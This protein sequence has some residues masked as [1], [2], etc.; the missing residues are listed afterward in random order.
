MN[1]QAGNYLDK[2]KEII[3]RSQGCSN[4]ACIPGKAH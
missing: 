1:D 2:I 4:W 3:I